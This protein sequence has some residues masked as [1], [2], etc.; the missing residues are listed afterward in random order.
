MSKYSKCMYQVPDSSR[1]FF[2]YLTSATTI[3]KFLLHCSIFLAFV[4]G[5]TACDRHPERKGAAEYSDLKPSQSAATRVLRRGLPG[6]P[7]TLDPQLADDDFSF[8]VVR[9]L[10]E[11]LTDEDA[12]GQIVPGTADSWT[13][14]DTGTIYTFHLRSDAK[15]SNGDQIVAA[16]FVQGLRR[17]VDPKTASGS[18]SLLAVI[19]GASEII[20][21]RKPISELGVR[22]IG[23]SSVRIELE[24]PAP[25]IL[26]ILS[27]PIAAPVY[28]S[29]SFNS[30]APQSTGK[31]NVYNGAYILVNRVP[32]SFIELERNRNYWNSSRV[33]IEKVRYVNAESEATELRE[34]M[35]GQLE[36]T[37]TIPMPDLSR[38]IQTYSDEVQISPTLGTVYLALNLSKPPLKDSPPLRQA[39]SMAVDRDLIAERVM[40]GVT[41]AYSFVADGTSGYYPPKYD[42]ATWSREHQLAYAR[43]LF[44]RSGY[45]KK[46]PL[47]LKLYFNNNEGIQ[48]TMIAIAAS[49][50]QNLGIITELASDEFQVFLVGRKDHNRWDAVRLGWIADYDDPSSFLEIFSQG[51]NQNDPGYN[52]TLFNDLIM[53]A[54]LEPLADKRAL[55]LRNMEQ[56]LLNDY[57][58]IPIYF[59]KARRLVKPYV[60]GAHL[61]PM[62]RT[63]SKNLFWK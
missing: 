7:R 20:A 1:L 2:S 22:A 42:W 62:N 9:D 60:G 26:Q 19:K 34:Y 53:Q 52:S 8:Q 61:N 6:E 41:P 46:N 27:Q 5:E 17:A 10:S 38:V 32:G 13:L 4:A 55:L 63:Y 18:A 47:Q 28:A 21:T 50:K 25:F 33:K 59:L 56:A 57:P 31:I 29:T 44:E 40:M 43:S 37:F 45:S 23:D 51:S 49:W 16:E 58:I 54:R 36:M 24:H 11:G 14:D 39:L 30:T 12:Y 35:A 48:R 15:W 3:I